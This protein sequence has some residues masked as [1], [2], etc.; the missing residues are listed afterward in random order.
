VLIEPVGYTD[1]EVQ[2]L[3]EQVQAEYVVRYGGRDRTPVDPGEFAAPDGV[4]LVGRVDGRAVACGGFRR[5]DGTACE[6]K[7]MF[8]RPEHRGRGHARTLLAALEDAARGAGYG[9]VLLE[10]G[11]GQPEAIALYESSGYTRV[12]GFGL[13]RSS[14]NNRCYGKD[15]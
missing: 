2:D 13:Y 4:F 6:V 14:P 10:T 1:P 9:R 11:T 5:H 15:L 12:P 3:V 7:R 8:V